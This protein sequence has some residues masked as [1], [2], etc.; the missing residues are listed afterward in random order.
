MVMF[1]NKDAGTPFLAPESVDLFVTHPSYFNGYSGPHGEPEGQLNNASDRGYFI[2]K[3]IEVIKHMEMAL[4][5]TGTIAIG[6]PTT[7]YFYEII[8]RIVTETKLIFGPMFFWDFSDSS[9]NKEISGKENNI[10]LNLHKGQ[11]QVN[12]EYKLD[13]YTLVHPWTTP[14]LLKNKGYLGFINHSAPEIVFERIIGRYSKPGDTV[15]DLMG[16][17]GLALRIAKQMNRETVY[18]DISDEQVRIAKIIIDN[19]EDSQMELKRSEVVE[20][21]SKEIIDM[22]IGRMQAMNLSSNDIS[23]YVEQSRAE[24]DNVNGMLFDLLVKNGV[25]R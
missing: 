2:N 11:Q 23:T 12:T 25:I 9:N 10:F 15:A 24:L 4:K 3:I 16:G 6:F 8:A 19:K 13:S 17:T 18:N 14:E 5:P 7:D 1:Y 22:N 21:M 20:L